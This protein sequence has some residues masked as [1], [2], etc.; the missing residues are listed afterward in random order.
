VYKW[1]KANDAKVNC[2]GSVQKKEKKNQ[3]VLETKNKNKKNLDAM[4]YAVKYQIIC[5]SS[6]ILYVVLRYVVEKWKLIKKSSSW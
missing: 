4:L 2:T 6:K 1:I 3:R 5:E